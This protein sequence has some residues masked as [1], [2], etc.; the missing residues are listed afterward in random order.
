MR[1]TLCGH[2]PH[3]ARGYCSKCYDKLPEV[4]ARKLIYNR[5]RRAKIK[6]DR[7]NG[8]LPFP[9]GGKRQDLL[10]IGPLR[11]WITAKIQVYGVIRLASR[12]D[13]SVRRLHALRF[14]QSSVSPQLVDMMLINEGSTMIWELYGDV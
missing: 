7:D 6:K 10:P 14:E 2:Y 1:K 12:C 5:E 11:G 9:G 13:I 8:H 4:K 3:Q